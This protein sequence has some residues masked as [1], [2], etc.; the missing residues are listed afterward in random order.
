M[1]KKIMCFLVIIIFS[2]FFYSCSS[3]SESEM[4]ERFNK[5]VLENEGIYDLIKDVKID[6]NG[7]KSFDKLFDSVKTSKIKIENTNKSGDIKYLYIHKKDDSINF[8]LLQGNKVISSYD[9]KREDISKLVSSSDKKDSITIGELADY[10]KKEYDFSFVDIIKYN[11]NSDDFTYNPD[12]Q[13]FVMTK[14]AKINYI[15]S[16]MNN[17]AKALNKY[18]KYSTTS[19]SD[20]SQYLAVNGI[21]IDLE[22]GFKKGHFTTIIF[23]YTQK[24]DSFDEDINYYRNTS[25]S[26]SLDF[27]YK[28]NNK[29]KKIDIDGKVSTDNIDTYYKKN[30][31][32]ECADKLDLTFKGHIKKNDISI[33]VNIKEDYDDDETI[34][35]ASSDQK[36]TKYIKDI[37]NN[38]IKLKFTY[39]GRTIKLNSTIEGKA[40][41][42]LSGSQVVV[43]TQ[44][45]GYGYSQSAKVMAVDTSKN[46][47]IDYKGS[48]LIDYNKKKNSMAADIDFKT[49]KSKDIVVTGK[50]DFHNWINELSYSAECKI[51]K[52]KTM[53]MLHY[54][55]TYSEITENELPGVLK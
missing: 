4:K 28:F 1:F 6:I 41:Y 30:K 35:T 51:S 49:N 26:I 45:Y 2:I 33:S 13:H 37:K 50:L 19:Y 3:E 53:D 32:G 18:H 11:F 21:N 27:H 24:L 52:L 48:L 9:L 17:L 22:F 40:S 36:A 15:S 5:F 31:G 7:N 8:S 54:K 23:N 38:D 29:L 43:E 55:L 46:Y 12:N 10:L 20:V 34:N 44:Q 14:D 25:I 47:K 39:N 16:I 42:T